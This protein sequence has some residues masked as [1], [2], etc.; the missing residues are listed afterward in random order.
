MIKIFI[1]T[2][3]AIVIFFIR[4][5][6]VPLFIGIGLTCILDPLVSWLEQ[7]FSG[8]RGLC[9]ALAY[10]V[11]FIAIVGLI[12]GFANIISGKISARSLS[13]ALMSIKVYYLEY[14][15]VLSK[16]FGFAVPNATD[17]ARMLQTFGSIAFKIFVGIIVSLYLL[18]DKNYFLRLLNKAMHLLLPQKAH[19]ILREIVF[20]INGVVAAFLRGMFVDSVIVAFLSSLALAVIKVDYA[21]FIGCF[22]GIANVIPYFGPFFGMIPAALSAMAG[23]GV[24]FG[25]PLIHGL[26][27]VAVLFVVQQIECNFIYPRIIGQST[28]LHPLFVLVAVSIAG[29]FGGLLWMVLAVPIAGIIKI[30]VQVW[31]ERQ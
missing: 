31:A 14:E 11:V 6:L 8:K 4:G 12:L 25:G 13:D 17:I 16:L 7:K 21:V 15:E 26:L 27:A 9:V 2:V 28:G 23:G 22:A 3:F 20:E 1:I 29:Y 5:A 10:V 19:G 18:N 24:G 30:L